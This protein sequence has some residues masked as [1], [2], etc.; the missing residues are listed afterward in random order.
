MSF[1]DPNNI[2]LLE[3]ILFGLFA[4]AGGLLAYVLRTLN[5]EE[6]PKWFRG[7]VEALASGFIG[8]I[9][10]LACKAMGLDWRWSGAVVGVFGWLGAETSIMLLT[11]L[12]RTK[13]GIDTNAS[14]NDPK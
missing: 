7:L 14:D 8:L 6:R 12:V 5:M 10:M 1:R 9:A 4:A 2:S 13:L 3:T 11:K